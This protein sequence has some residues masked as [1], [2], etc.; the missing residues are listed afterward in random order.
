MKYLLICSCLILTACKTAPEPPRLERVQ[1]KLIEEV[2]V[3]GF[4]DHESATRTLAQWSADRQVRYEILSYDSD[5]ES[6]V[7]RIATKEYPYYFLKE[8][9]NKGHILTFDIKGRPEI[10][11]MPE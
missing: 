10:E 11:W 6:G 2:A 3:I 1:P 7:F 8:E 9:Q 4:L 5:I